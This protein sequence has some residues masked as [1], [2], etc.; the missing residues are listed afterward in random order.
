MQNLTVTNLPSFKG[1]ITPDFIKATNILREFKNQGII[2]PSFETYR[3]I[4]PSELRERL[5]PSAQVTKKLGIAPY[6]FGKPD[7]SIEIEELNVANSDILTKNKYYSKLMPILNSK[8]NG[9][10]KLREL[11][12]EKKSKKINPLTIMKGLVE[13]FKI[14]NCMEQ[15]IIMQDKLIKAG[16]PAKVTGRQFIDHCF[17]VCNLSKNANI[18]DHKT[19]G[20]RAFIVDPWLNRVFR[21]KE[22]AFSEYKRIYFNSIEHLRNM[23]KKERDIGWHKYHKPE[24]ICS[25]IP[26]KEKIPFIKKLT[27]FFFNLGNNN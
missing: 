9:L 18:K 11:L 12:K 25:Y 7:V 15:S 23:S 27:K 8:E 2:S 13:K 21:S 6:S 5:E 10:C 26:M 16:I 14:G 1:R 4:K 22:E 17:V 3:H 24:E 20:K 19:W